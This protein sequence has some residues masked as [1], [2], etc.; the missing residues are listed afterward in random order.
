L[1]LS[2]SPLFPLPSL[3]LCFTHISSPS[4]FYRRT[5]THKLSKKKE[6][7]KEIT[8]DRQ[9]KIS[10]NGLLLP[11]PLPLPLHH[12]SSRSRPRFS[13]GL[14]AMASPSPTF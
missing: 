6:R 8:T 2:T 4:I 10:K 9:W 7:K 5:L 1:F 14:R 13:R 3:S 11:L 12:T